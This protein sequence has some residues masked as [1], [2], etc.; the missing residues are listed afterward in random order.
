MRY[1]GHSIY[2]VPYGPLGRDV[3]KSL[4]AL[5]RLRRRRDAPLPVP[6]F[7]VPPTAAPVLV[8]VPISAPHSVARVASPPLSALARST[9][10]IIDG[11]LSRSEQY[12]SNRH[13]TSCRLR[14]PYGEDTDEMERGREREA[15]VTVT[16]IEGRSGTY[17]LSL[18]I[19]STRLETTQCCILLCADVITLLSM[20]MRLERHPVTRLVKAMTL[21]SRREKTKKKRT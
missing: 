10:Y 6:P 5:S 4:G 3:M 13:V 1:E 18:C 16:V 12:M 15:A 9:S 17:G 11:G 2:L 21:S 20:K 14:D 8:R 19:P 7:T